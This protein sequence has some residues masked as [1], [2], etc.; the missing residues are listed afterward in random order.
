M[1]Y[2]LIPA[3]GNKGQ[4][5]FFQVPHD[6]DGG[7]NANALLKA[8]QDTVSEFEPSVGHTA[9]KNFLNLVDVLEHASKADIL[10]VYSQTKNKD[11][12]K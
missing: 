5:V 8:L 2:C 7:A 4:T 12:A 11:T 10:A 9:A 1:K 3:N 6:K